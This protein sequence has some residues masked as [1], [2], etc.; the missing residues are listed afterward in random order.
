[1]ATLLRLIYIKFLIFI[2]IYKIFQPI[3]NNF[4]KIN[5]MKSVYFFNKNPEVIRYGA[6]LLRWISPFYVLCCFNQILAGALRGAG[7]SRAPMLIMLIS[8]VAFRQVYMFVMSNFIC[9]EI[10]PIAMGYPA[11][12]L[13]SSLLSFAYYKKVDLKKK[14]VV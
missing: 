14:V 12:W 8:F 5:I 6:L 2:I 10:I 13:L 9:N 7:N 11:G 3:H 4:F 1:M